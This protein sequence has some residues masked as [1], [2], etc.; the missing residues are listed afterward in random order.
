[1]KTLDIK[2]LDRDR[3]KFLECLEGKNINFLFGAGAS[4]PYLETLQIENLFYSF[5]DI[6]D[7]MYSS[8]SKGINF[9]NAYFAYRSLIN[10][11]YQKIQENE[12]CDGVKTQYQK[13]IENMYQ[14][15]QRTSVQQ[16]KR[17]NI[18]STNY[19]MFFEA[20]FDEL[21]SKNKYICFNDGSVGFMNKTVTTQTFHQKVMNVGVDNRFDFELPMF[22]LIK[23]HGSLNWNLKNGQIM[24][25]NT[26]RL[27]SLNL[28]DDTFTEFENE[29][30]DFSDL[31]DIKNHLE[32]KVLV[33]DYDKVNEIVNKL[34]IVKP[35]EDKFAET[36]LQ[37]HFYQCLRVLSQELERNQSILVVFGFSFNDEHIYNIVKRS[38]TN[39]GLMV[40]IVCF[41]D[42]SVKQ[43]ESQ[44]QENS[45]VV[46]IRNKTSIT[47]GN[48]TFQFL[49]SILGGVSNE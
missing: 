22:N 30:E 40:Y 48:G 4:M 45:N 5:E 23:L 24:I 13:F 43:F 39:P 38:M 49:N 32:Y 19:D 28:S 20:C 29:I 12:D 9:L 11:T 7:Y 8:G 3:K 36:V 1:M 26:Y 6:Y 2:D 16:P 42:D 46:L 21:A 15:L 33:E 25:D 41:D 47:G 31:N 34:L 27:E 18:F 37:E 35:K 14:I 17:V 44:F 10:G